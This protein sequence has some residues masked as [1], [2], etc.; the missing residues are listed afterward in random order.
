MHNNGSADFMYVLIICVNEVKKKNT[1]YSRVPP[2]PHKIKYIIMRAG[3]ET[4]EIIFHHINVYTYQRNDLIYWSKT[5][6]VCVC[7]VDGKCS[8]FCSNIWALVLLKIMD[9]GTFKC[10]KTKF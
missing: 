5:L 1:S 3:L 9:S 4:S 8:G 7:L 2:T 6:C 10:H